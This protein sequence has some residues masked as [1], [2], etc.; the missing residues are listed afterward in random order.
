MQEAIN[1]G[2][3]NTFLNLIF[4]LTS[5]DFVFVSQLLPIIRESLRI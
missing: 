1:M 2:G 5:P 4:F 3:K